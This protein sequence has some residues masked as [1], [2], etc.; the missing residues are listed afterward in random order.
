M[1]GNYKRCAITAYGYVCDTG[2]GIVDVGDIAVGEAT[3]MVQRARYWAAARHG[4]VDI[5]Q[6]GE[7][8]YTLG[9]C[10]CPDAAPVSDSSPMPKRGP[11]VEAPAGDLSGRPIVDDDSYASGGGLDP[12]RARRSRKIQ[13]FHWGWISAVVAA[14]FRL[15]ISA[16]VLDGYSSTPVKHAHTSEDEGYPHDDADRTLLSTPPCDAYAHVVSPSSAKSNSESADLV[17]GDCPEI[18]LRA[19]FRSCQARRRW[20]DHWQHPGNYAT[21]CSKEI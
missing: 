19:G 6:P 21:E 10:L 4:G 18:D 20:T 5:E 15:T 3:W 1:F 13:T 14:Q 9:L 16:Y 2:H 8:A 7:A 17:A 12:S 11:K